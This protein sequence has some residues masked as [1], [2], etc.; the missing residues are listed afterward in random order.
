MCVTRK[1]V[2]LINSL[3]AAGIYINFGEDVL[4]NEYEIGTLIEIKLPIVKPKESDEF[5]FVDEI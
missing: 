1:R 2:N 4:N 5:N 3:Y